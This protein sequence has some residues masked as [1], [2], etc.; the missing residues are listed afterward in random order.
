[1]SYK[2]S[3][4]TAQ[5]FTWVHPSCI[6]ANR[7]MLQSAGCGC[8]LLHA[9][10]ARS[11]LYTNPTTNPYQRTSTQSDQHSYTCQQ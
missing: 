7:A 11:T 1:M 9:T 6:A 8:C 4:I 3:V 2:I 10:D 5:A